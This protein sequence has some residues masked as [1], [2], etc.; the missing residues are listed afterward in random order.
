V[1][2]MFVCICRAVTEDALVAAAQGDSR[3]EE[4]V[5]HKLGAGTVCGT[6]RDRVSALFKQAKKAAP[7]ADGSRGS[8]R[9]TTSQSRSE[10]RLGEA[11]GR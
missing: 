9:G 4:E 10:G 1:I 7:P 6:C 11:R 3:G 2:V 5:V 8:D